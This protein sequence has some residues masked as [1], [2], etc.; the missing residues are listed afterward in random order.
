M[1][2]NLSRFLRANLFVSFSNV[3]VGLLNWYFIYFLL[4][5]F[6]QGISNDIIS[7]TSLFLLLTIPASILNLIL[8]KSGE[9][10][11]TS[12]KNNKIVVLVILL[13][14]LTSVF[15][16][17]LIYGL[18]ANQ[19]ILMCILVILILIAYIYKS[20]LQYHLEYLKLILISIAEVI[21]KILVV[22]FTFKSISYS[23][24]LS[25]I[26]QYIIAAFG[27]FLIYTKYIPKEFKNIKNDLK[28]GFQTILTTSI[29]TILLGININID[30]IIGNLALNTI[31]F[32]SYLKY[33][34]ISK[35]LLFICLSLNMILLSYLEKN[36][37]GLSRIKLTIYTSLIQLFLT[38]SSIIG[39]FIFDSII[40]NIFGISN[41]S[42]S[43]AYTLLISTG[44]FILSTTFMTYFV[45]KENW[46]K[47]LILTI[48]MS[49]I[50]IILYLNSHTLESFIQVNLIISSIFFFLVII[51]NFSKIFDLS[52]KF[53]RNYLYSKIQNF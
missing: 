47:L 36:N 37:L 43:Y 35:I 45:L 29:F 44:V 10:F 46:K 42:S 8:I 53:K 41:Y 7:F 32:N 39:L 49:V 24:Y 20:L 4:Q 12:I 6:N 21:L 1:E 18:K 30:S 34:Q 15:V 14:Y 16:L 27:S 17:C 40:V 19:A 23:G 33:T 31:D 52:L 50:Q 5:N 25:L 28:I 13:V 3:L 38:L 48:C 2:L 51:L 11:L 26:F 22:V 9:Q